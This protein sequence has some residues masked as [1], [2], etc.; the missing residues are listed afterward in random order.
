[1]LR[2]ELGSKATALASEASD[3]AG[4]IPA[5]LR[6]GLGGLS[7]PAVAVHRPANVRRLIHFVAARA[8]SN[9]QAPLLTLLLF[10]VE[11]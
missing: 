10:Y 4:C 1:V 8:A 9:R 11:L 3:D 7:V 5:L 2:I 6:L